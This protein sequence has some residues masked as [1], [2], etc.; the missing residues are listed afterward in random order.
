[1]WDVEKIILMIVATLS[2][3]FLGISP[4]SSLQRGTSVEKFEEACAKRTK[5]S[6][7]F[8]EF[9]G[10]FYKIFSRNLTYWEEV[11]NL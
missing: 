5:I 2:H 6:N 11:S 1:M 8:H 10:L 3:E 7:I 4:Y 9:D